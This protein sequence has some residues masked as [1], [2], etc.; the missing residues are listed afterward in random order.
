[1]VFLQQ[2]VSQDPNEQQTFVNAVLGFARSNR[3]IAWTPGPAWAATQQYVTLQ[4][5]GGSTVTTNLTLT[6][7]VGPTFTVQIPGGASLPPRSDAITMNGNTAAILSG[8]SAPAG[9]FIV[10]GATLP[11]S[12]S[13]RG[14]IQ[15]QVFIPQSSLS[16]QQASAPS[17][18]LG[19]SF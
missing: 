2:P 7:S 11:F 15:I 4:G 9:A 14:C 1:I 12:G 8:L 17:M 10:P 6:F 13:N 16:P 3:V 18:N 5:G 19:F